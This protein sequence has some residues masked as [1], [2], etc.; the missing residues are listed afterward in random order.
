MRR[1]VPLVWVSLLAAFVY[2]HAAGSRPIEIETVVPH[3][4]PP[5]VAAPAPSSIEE[6]ERALE[7][8][9]QRERVAGLGV[10]LIGK[11]GPIWV[12][13]VGVRDR[14]TRDPVAHDTVFRIGSLSKTVIALG[15]MRLVDQGKLSV[16]RPLREIVPDLEFDNPWEAESP[17]TLAHVLEHTAGFDDVR[18]NEIFTK[19][20]R[21]T[22][23]D[24]L[25]LNSRSRNVRWRPGTRHGYSN[26]G[27]TVAARAI[28]VASGEPFDVYLKREILQPIGIADAEFHRTDALA[29][30]LA[31]GYMQGP[32]PVPFFPF[33]HRPSGSLLASA[34]DLGKLV[35]FL[36][37]RGE[38]YNVVSRAGLERIEHGGTLPYPR[39]DTEYGFAN[40][41]DVHHPMIMRG[42][43]GGMPGFHSSFRYIPEL[44]VGYAFLLNSNYTFRGYADI[45][46]LLYAYVTRGHPVAA[47]PAVAAAERPKAS[48]YALGAPRSALFAFLDRIRVG[49][50]VEDLGDHVHLADLENGWHAELHPTPD[51]GYRFHGDSGS[52]VRFTT[53]AEGTPIILM[54]FQY[55]EAADGTF[56]YLKR[57]ALS[58][59]MSMLELALPYAISLVLLGLM[60]GRRFVPM[61]VLLWSSAASLS[62]AAMPHLLEGA[63][64]VGVIGEVHPLTVM[65][66]GATILFAIASL[67][68]LVTSVRALRR[69]TDRAFSAEHGRPSIVAMIFPLAC[70]I[71]FTGFALLLG[72]NGLIGL[73]TWAW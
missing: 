55:G 56:T 70:G 68:T 53:N 59:T 47:R 39:V 31:S 41:A 32:E 34:D 15:V 42:H 3:S 46:A 60:F 25:A 27:Y 5:F 26:V 44:G 58:L 62:C 51:G 73:R 29:S 52:S 12:G 22:V 7:K 11:D 8:I 37:V 9:I 33:A 16:D 72:A 38:G 1:V 71:A 66:C 35:R 20:E 43:D 65:L 2:L 45:R 6:L 63:F 10:A 48:F 67:A 69:T 30:R 4:L 14:A 57:A 13:G 24:T 40:Y 21:I 54:H 23:R 17:V 50:Q 36:A 61:S 64:M 18:F 19:E 28:E 49:W